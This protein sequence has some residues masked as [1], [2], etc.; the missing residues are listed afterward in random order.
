LIYWIRYIIQYRYI[1]ACRASVLWQSVRIEVDP[2]AGEDRPVC[3]GTERPADQQGGSR[4]GPAAAGVMDVTGPFWSY[5]R[6]AAEPY[7]VS[8]FRC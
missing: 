3:C 5:C 8:R 4:D 7:M 1:L 6:V 2:A